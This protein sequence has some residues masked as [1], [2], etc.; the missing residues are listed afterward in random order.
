MKKQTGI[1]LSLAAIL[2]FHLP[3]AATANITTGNIL[4]TGGNGTLYE[5]TPSGGF[6][7]STGIATQGGTE[8]LRDVVVDSN[9][10][11]QLYNGTFSPTLTSYNPNNGTSTQTSVAGWSTVNN[12]TYGGISAYGNYAYVTDMATAGS[13]SPNGLIRFNVNDLSNQ[14][15]ASGTDF[16]Q[17][18][19][20]RDGL[21][22]GLYPGGSPD[23][24]H[25]AVYDPNSLSLVRTIN[26]AVQLRGLAV[27]ASGNIFGCSLTGHIY[28]LDSN[29][30]VLADLS[31]GAILADLAMSAT[32]QIV[33]TEPVLAGKFLLTDTSLTSFSSVQLPNGDTP[34][35]MFASF[36]EAPIN[37][38]APEPSSLCL[39]GLGAAGYWIHR[40]RARAKSA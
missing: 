1:A 25:I 24:T 18:A 9:G 37:S 8:V 11:V 7:Q 31:T 5:F 10:N 15:F 3:A 29:G 39:V 32:G 28:R 14:R 26:L 16:I 40:R 35:Y 23:G 2:F 6:V 34:L 19:T 4:V 12:G 27:D 38:T 33:V 36:A 22:Y 30:N 17:V 20:G 21:L 13:G